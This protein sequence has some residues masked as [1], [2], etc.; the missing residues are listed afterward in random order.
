[1]A[2]HPAVVAA[3]EVAAA[4]RTKEAGGSVGSGLDTVIMNDWLRWKELP[5]RKKDRPMPVSFRTVEPGE[6]KWKFPFRANV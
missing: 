4:G 1:M 5:I 3:V 6:M 2:D